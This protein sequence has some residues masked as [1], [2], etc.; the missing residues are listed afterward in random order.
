MKQLL[1]LALYLAMHVTAFGQTRVEAFIMPGFGY[2]HMSL[3]NGD[4]SVRDSLNDMDRVRQNWG[5]GVKFLFY[6]D[7]FSALQVGLHYKGLSFTRVKEDLQFHDTV[8]PEIG[9]IIDLSQ[10]IAQ[11][12][13]YFYHRYRYLSIPVVYQKT[14]TRQSFNN[15]MQFFFSSGL[16]FDFLINDKTSVALPG[17]S[18][19]GEDRFTINNDYS[20]S[21]FNIGLNLGAR[22]EYRLDEH[23]NFSVQP[24]FSYPLLS[25]AKDELVQFRLFQFGMAVGVNYLL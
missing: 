12:D 1:I 21:S 14:F 3:N 23:S 5:G 22:F 16:D 4:Q 11:K 15:K 17:F 7:K 2:H 13:A 10:T 9:R 24:A 20:S 25:T 8:H 18:V 6:L 19:K